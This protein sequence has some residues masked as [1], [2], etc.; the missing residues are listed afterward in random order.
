V[1]E[2]KIQGADGDGE[3]EKRKTASAQLI[4]LV[5]NVQNINAEAD[6]GTLQMSLNTYR[7]GQPKSVV[8]SSP[9]K[10]PIEIAP[11]DMPDIIKLV[12]PNQQLLRLLLNDDDEKNNGR[13]CAVQPG[14]ILEMTLQG[15]GGLRT[16][17]YFLVSH[18][19][20]PYSERDIIF[21]VTDVHQT[22][23]AGNWETT[24]RAQPLPL[25]AYIRDR[26]T[27]PLGFN[28]TNNGWPELTPQ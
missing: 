4:D 2:K 18:L 7:K 5:R 24:V 15:I 17:Q 26:V 1:P 25:R 28:V 9:H 14:I 20:E 3:L 22:L 10:K 13:Y 8:I 12:L 11:D 19:P 23:E 21:R 16:F 27:G 6:S